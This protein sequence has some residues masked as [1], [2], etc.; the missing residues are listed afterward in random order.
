[1]LYPS[2]HEPNRIGLMTE[3]RKGFLPYAST[4]TQRVQKPKSNTR[5]IA[6]VVAF[7]F[8]GLAAFCVFV[9]S[10]ETLMYGQDGT[11]AALTIAVPV[12]LVLATVL[13]AIAIHVSVHVSGGLALSAA[14]A[15]W[16]ILITYLVYAILHMPG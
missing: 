2:R 1:M 10:N 6:A 8:I 7:M 13:S 14:I 3:P 5:S 15:G 11:L 4:T 12:C 9:A 16:L